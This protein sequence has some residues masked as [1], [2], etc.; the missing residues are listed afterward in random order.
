MGLV[1]EAEDIK[2]KRRVALK[3]LAPE[4]IRDP[5]S[6][7][8][9]IREAQASSKLDH[10]NICTIYE[11]NE[12]KN[13]HL[14]IA[15]AFCQGRSLKERLKSEPLPVKEAVEIAI[16]VS[17]GLAR[18]H[19]EGIIHRDIK[20]GN[21]METDRGEVK[22]VDFGLAKLAEDTEITQTAGFMGTIAYMSPEQIQGERLDF[23]TDIWSVGVVM[24]EMLT[25]VHPFKGESPRAVI[26]AVLNESPLAPAEIRSD[27]PSSLEKIIFKCLAKDRR[28]RYQ[29]A[30]HLS[31]DLGQ[32]RR[33]IEEE[34]LGAGIDLRRKPPVKKETEQRQ[35]TV[36]FVEIDGISEILE[37]VEPQEAAS[38]LRHCA[39]CFDFIEDVY[40]GKVDK[41]TDS[42]F[43]AVFGFPTA[44]ENAPEKAVQAAM[45]LRNKID[46]LNA[47]ETLGTPLR[48]RIGMSSGMVIVGAIETDEQS[49]Y[50]VMGDAVTLASQLKDVSED[51]AISVGPAT[52]RKTKEAFAYRPLE[53][54]VWKGRDKP[55][56]VFELLSA[57]E[58]TTRPRLGWDRTISSEL[59]GREKELDRLQLQVL[60]AINGEGSIVNLIGEAGIGKS[61]LM[62]ELKAGAV[63]AKV[64]L[65]EGRAL[66]IGKNLSFHPLIDILKNWAEIK[67]D[68]GTVESG[69]KLEKAIRPLGPESLDDI[70]PF[71]AT[72]MGL[73]PGGRYAERVKGIEGEALEKL[74]LKSLR[75]LMEKASRRKPLVI[76]IEDLHWADLTTIRFLESIF[77][78]AENNPVVF[79]NVFR[80]DYEETSQRLLR[81]IH[82][83]YSRVQT[84]IVLGPLDENESERLIHNLLKM[85]ALPVV[86]RELIKKR[87]EGNPFF[88]EE[89]A[90]S[91]IDD[92]VVEIKDGAFRVTDKINSVVIPETIHELLMARIDKLNE[93]TKSLLKI[94]S[95]IGRNFFYKIL[96]KVADA[97]PEI[98]VKLDTL[99]ESQLIRERKSQ[100]E[101]EY[102]FKHAL[103]QEVTYQ[104]ILPKKR[105]ELHLKIANAIESVFSERLPEFYGMLAFHFSKGEDL[106]KA[107]TY[108]IQA[109]QEALKSSASNEALHYYQAAL[110]IYLGKSGAEADPEKIAMLQKNI[111]IALY[112]RGRFI[113]AIDYFEKAMTL[114]GEKKPQGTLAGTVRF[115]TG[116]L[117]FLVS[118]YLPALKFRRIPSRREQEIIDLFKRKMT[119][120]S[121]TIPKR[122][123]IESFYFCKLFV[124]YDL[125]KVENGLSVFTGYSAIFSW[126]GISFTLSRKILEFV[127]DKLEPNDTKALICYRFCELIHHFFKGDWNL[128]PKCDERLVEQSLKIGEFFFTTTYLDVLCHLHIERGNLDVARPFIQKVDEIYK[129]FEYD[130]AKDE[131]HF[132]KTL[133]LVKSRK[134]HEALREAQEGL[135]FAQ[136]GG[137][138]PEAFSLIAFKAKAQILL[139][140]PEGAEKT[141]QELEKIQSK[142][143]A[144]PLYISWCLLSQF[145]LSLRRLETAIQAGARHDVVKRR[146]QAWRWGQKAL[147]NS[148]K[149]ASERTEIYQCLGNFFWIRGQQKRA[150]KWWTKSVNQAKKLGACLELS[151]TYLEAGKRLME[152][153][154]R[155]HELNK[156]SAERLRQEANALCPWMNL[157]T[158]QEP[159][160]V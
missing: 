102:L 46:E 9:F 73:R 71:I 127:K 55:V 14:F 82:S 17:Q 69:Q 38:I 2:L 8:R 20:P 81:T 105:K 13:H 90:R 44:I 85:S 3:F 93:D 15:M 150:L 92:G 140:D 132:L 61:R 59:V 103:V 153:T 113:E 4:L 50:T 40:G 124:N 32:L 63:M 49:G 114:Y 126:P 157:P 21:I 136:Q 65:V 80:P 6:K 48:L 42:S 133:L 18:A 7:Q 149:I 129:T 1:Y 89:V 22:I 27:I 12:D 101:V 99:K 47:S 19:E 84:E 110:N 112:D 52:F 26:H 160:N 145:L 64:K 72:L 134:I 135:A 94:A 78:L 108:L 142:E 23:R 144:V 11:I 107:E 115:L 151:R 146:R 30:R 119:A 10:Q 111:G 79:M 96:V 159:W 43:R 45:E 138:T 77:R 122:M 83:R 28:E 147:K 31:S 152:K 56:R 86:V 155:Y 109:G 130:Y 67:E 117:N 41:M 131:V 35:A 100:E 62:A 141:L 98:D 76:I 143:N 88:I 25:G 95:V 66:S 97:I 54:I 125:T 121:V 70:F 39:A 53:P 116:F 16:Q 5:E 57:K 60:K 36:M 68:D 24:Y 123:F 106:E 154:S 118:L 120:L 156:V 29:T 137:Y 104:S 58:R 37:A 33:T 148:R 87:A 51:G 75:E 128:I 34:R 158:D 91:F 139:D 74:I